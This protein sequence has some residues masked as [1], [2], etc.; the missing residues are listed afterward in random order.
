MNKKLKFTFYSILKNED[1]NPFANDEIIAVADGLGGSGSTIHQID[2]TQF[3]DLKEEL[4]KSAFFDFEESF[5]EEYSEYFNHL[6]EP[7]IDGEN[8][9]SAL[10]ASRIVI[11]RYIY[12]LLKI[13]EFKYGDLSNEKTREKLSEFIK[14]G[15]VKTANHFHL[16]KGKYDNQLILPTTLAGFRYRVIDGKIKAEVLWAGDSRCY[17]LNK[18]GLKQVSVDDENFS[19]EITNLFHS[20]SSPKLNYKCI[21]LEEPYVLIAVSD[22]IF[23]PFTK[24]PEN[25]GVEYILLESIKECDSIENLKQILLT[26]YNKIHADDSTMVFIPLGFDNYD[27]LKTALK[28]RTSYILEMY[29]RFCSNEKFMT[30]KD[31]P[32]EEADLYIKNRI[33]D[34]YQN[35]S[36]IIIEYGINQKEDIVL[37]NEI[38]NIF[39]NVDLEN[40]EELKRINEEKTKV[41]LSAL[42]E[43]VLQYNEFPFKNRKKSGILKRLHKKFSKNKKYRTKIKSLKQEI[44]ELVSLKELTYKDIRTCEEEILNLRNHLKI[45][46]GNSICDETVWDDILSISQFLLTAERSLSTN[47]AMK[48]IIPS[49]HTSSNSIKELILKLNI[50]NK[51][52]LDISTINK[53]QEQLSALEKSTAIVS[54]EIKKILH[55]KEFNNHCLPYVCYDK[56]EYI[57]L[58]DEEIESQLNEIKLKKIQNIFVEKKD[59]II[60]D[61]L[62]NLSQYYN[63]SSIIDSSFHE[64]HLKQFRW[65]HEFNASLKEEF[66]KFENEWNEL[67]KSYL[68]LINN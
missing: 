59:L 45:N 50:L 49:Q 15:L 63:Q 33:Y 57:P 43:K 47:K 41:I 58:T 54:T 51:N 3:L 17:V 37:S 31:H 56:I 13:E 20:N 62:K 19:G 39:T 6:L 22:G 2:K 9:T 65:L 40:E 32:L 21:E 24:V 29:Q 8:D 18:K 67:G 52:L 7:M 28:E 11:A 60:E 4:K 55:S 1:A 25:F 35:I 38:K 42:Q 10:W 5:M 16:Q 27:E 64:S 30:I 53:L 66:T 12:A 34:K 26:Q 61:I 68:D 23:D 46:V 36:D 14:L 44:Q 48:L